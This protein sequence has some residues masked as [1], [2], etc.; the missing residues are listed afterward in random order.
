MSIIWTLLLWT[1]H[2][3]N[4]YPIL[5][6]IWSNYY[7]FGTVFR[8]LIWKKLVLC[9]CPLTIVTFFFLAVP[10]IKRISVFTSRYI[11][12]FSN[13]K[14]IPPEIVAVFTEVLSLFMC[15]FVLFFLFIFLL[16]NYFLLPF[17]WQLNAGRLQETEMGNKKESIA[18]WE[19]QISEIIQW[20][21]PLHSS[22][23]SVMNIACIYP[24]IFLFFDGTHSCRKEDLDPVIF[25]WKQSKF[26]IFIDRLIRKT[27][28]M[29]VGSAQQSVIG[30]ISA[31]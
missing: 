13:C 4:L 1:S 6:I 7:C 28:I 26:T 22:L 3:Y 21:V 29:S 2:P 9:K 27:E 15:S 20:W 23:L 8:Q 25:Y 18:Q 10:S 5:I 30:H 17:L 16:F 14:M 12:K 31:N 19:A 24:H 11:T